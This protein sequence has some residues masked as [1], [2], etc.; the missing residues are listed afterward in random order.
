MERYRRAYRRLLRVFPADFLAG[1]GEDMEA[2]FVDRL[3]GLRGA[4]PWAR[5]SFLVGAVLDV[6][7]G[8]AAERFVAPGNFRRLPVFAIQ[9]VKYA[10]RLLAKSP[11]FTVLTVLILGGGLG[12]SVFTYSF[13]RTA[14]LA[15]LPL[16]EGERVV[17][18]LGQS[19]GGGSQLLDAADIAAIRP[20]IRNLTNLGLYTGRVLSL[21][22]EGRGLSVDA[23]ATESSLFT[24]AGIPPILGRVIQPADGEPGAEPVM[25]LSHRA[26]EVGL[27]ADSAVV[28]TTIVVNGTPTRLVGVMPPRFGF[29][30]AAEA[31]IPLRTEIA[32]ATTPGVYWVEGFARLAVGT[33]V[34]RATAELAT[35]LEAARRERRAPGDTTQASG[36]LLRSFPEAQI[37]DEAPLILVVM[38]GL[39]A[40]VLLLA[41]INVGN[42]LLARANERAR[43][44]AVR[45]AL[46]ASRPRLIMQNLWESVIL[47]LLGGAVAVGLAAGG[48]AVIDRWSWLYLEG[49]LAFWW[50]WRFGGSDLL[51]TTGFI[52][53]AI[54]GLGGVV[55]YR[56]TTTELTA[57]L[58]E[59]GVRGGG[60]REGRAARFLVA[61]QVAAVSVL[62]FVGVMAGIVSHRVLR[63]DVGH[64]TENLLSGAIDLPADR[65]RDSTAAARYFQ[66]LML[67][68]QGH[69][70]IAHLLLQAPLAAPQD[71]GGRL[72]VAARER[73][74]GSEPRAYQLA[75]AG[76]LATL[77]VSV[78]Q[79]RE[80]DERDRTGPA[81]VLVSRALAEREWPGETPIGRQL[82]FSGAADSARW[83]T[84]VGVVGNVLHG[85]PLSRERSELAVYR[86][87]VRLDLR[88]ASALIKHRGDEAAT[89]SALLETMAFLDPTIATDRLE[90]YSEAL[91]MMGRIARGTVNLLSVCFGFALLIALT[92]TYG[93]MARSIGRRTREIGVRRA[94]GATDRTILRLLLGQGSR[95]L[96][97]GAVVALPITA[98]AGVAF[99]S[100]F[101]IGRGTAVAIAVGVAVAIAAVVLAATYLPTR[102]AVA[103][104]PREALWRE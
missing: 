72:E 86:P 15:P 46:G 19:P 61:T 59:G 29:P 66:Q 88:G 22:S 81:T 38:N 65:I 13:L 94:L 96:A 24:V 77:G 14:V 3:R 100:V 11:V 68:T 71:E 20:S 89:R 7:L 67:R 9:D 75:I 47:C 36:I 12:V 44:T 4:G 45:L 74:R 40:L 104:E 10:I 48:L 25:V 76:S 2:T 5:G 49:N 101:P 102:R 6:L 73:A 54:A 21:G 93:L 64:D 50:V 99:A 37:G 27:G 31:W 97:I 55:S 34:E 80:F 98:G 85:N 26:W 58:A 57:V 90:S 42:L 69:P 16:V 83:H 87:M 56:A 23:T 39:A 70:A 84:V 92:G 82:R 8:A 62:M 30:V 32:A 60:R 91:A 17:K 43:E 18:I 28:G 52:T 35:L 79:G 51:A 33:T 41:C 95:Q 63:L 53:L 78:L 103:L 1:Y